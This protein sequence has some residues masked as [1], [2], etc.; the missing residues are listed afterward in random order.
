MPVRDWFRI[1][2]SHWIKLQS[3]VVSAARAYRM[4]AS[5][6]EIACSTN[7]GMY[8]GLSEANIRS[9]SAKRAKGLAR[10]EF[11]AFVVD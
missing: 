2:V 3:V 5:S 4:L 10:F 1:L 11:S 9:S 7:F 6:N 8:G